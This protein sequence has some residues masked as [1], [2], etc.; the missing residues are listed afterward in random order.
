MIV[1][2]ASFPRS[3]NT[4]FRIVSHH[5]FNISTYSG[6]QSGNSDLDRA[7]IG[8]IT[9]HKQ[10]PPELEKGLKANDE[11]MWRPYHEADEIYLI[12]THARRNELFSTN[13]PTVLLVRDGRDAYV[14]LAW[15][16]ITVAHA[17]RLESP[18]RKTKLMVLAEKAAIALGLKRVLFRRVLD[19]LVNGTRW[20]DFND[21]WVTEEHPA[22]AT[23]H[24]RDLVQDPIQSCHAALTGVGAIA[25]QGEA[26]D[27]PDFE[28]LHQQYPQFFRKGSRGNWHD[29]MSQ[30]QADAYWRNHGKT[31]T[32]LGYNKSHEAL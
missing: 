30:T 3:G 21:S 23:L 26:N 7:G 20:A 2:L 28:A 4:F 6:F 10:L 19:E 32:T 12:K 22:L 25:A 29:E 31:M 14:S 13:L 8:D 18:S 24:F 11:S 16:W 5:V 1:W 17:W 9:G 27:L 15:Y